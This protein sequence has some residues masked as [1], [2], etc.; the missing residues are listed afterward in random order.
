MKRLS[1]LLIVLALVAAAAA[2]TWPRETKDLVLAEDD[3]CNLDGRLVLRLDSFSVPLYPS[4]MPRQYM[5]SIKTLDGATEKI[6]SADVSVNHPF[7]QNGWWIF[8]MGGGIDDTITSRPVPCSV[9]RCVR[10]PFL[11]LAAAAGVLAIA[12]ALLLCFVPY[13]PD[14]GRATRLRRAIAWCAAAVVALLPVFIIARAVFAPE[15]P[16]ALQSV[17]MAPHVASYAASYLIL[18]FAAFGIWRRAVPA[19]FLLMT[20]GLVVGALWGKIAWSDWWQFD[21]K[22]N[23]SLA[24][25]CAFA[26]H[27]FLPRGSRL[28][29]VFFWTGILLMIVTLTWVN[30]SKATAGLH[31]YVAI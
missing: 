15:P 18:L 9:I 29:R 14:A 6:T 23:W 19:G 1:F 4:G 8:Q 2:R 21:P 12:G 20:A 30:F 26:L 16:P 10:D 7:R 27:L 13:A 17:L 28:S 22:E 11:P 24:T 3:R 31:S 25:W 5:S